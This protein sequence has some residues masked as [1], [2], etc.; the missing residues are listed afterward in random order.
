MRLQS[1]IGLFIIAALAWAI[2]ENKRKVSLK[3]VLIG[4]LLQFAIA[5][6]LLKVPF[7]QNIFMV[8]NKVVISLEDAT[9][10]GTSF[11]FGY[12]GGGPLPFD[13]KY[14][15]SS[16]ILALQA[17]P[18]VLVVSALSSLLFYLRI[19]PIIVKAFSFILEKTLKLGGALG[20]G[21]A[22]N[23]FV[24]MIESPLLIKPYFK[25]MTR[26]ELFSVMTCGMA[27]IAGT[28]MVVYASVLR[29]DTP[30]FIYLHTS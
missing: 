15:G 23:I 11:V 18:L 21:A 8:L 6:L 29:K 5:A 14:P 27:T 3:G 22:A 17:L 26:S 9:R 16:F 4:I 28:V 2:S 1:F 7:S 30:P 24:G 25:D 10:A 20:L 13:E 19:L 12:I